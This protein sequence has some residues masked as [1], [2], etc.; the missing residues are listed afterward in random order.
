MEINLQVRSVTFS[1]EIQGEGTGTPTIVL[2]AGYGE[3]SDTWEPVVDRLSELGEVFRYDRAGLGRSGK[4]ENPRTSREM[5]KELYDLLKAAGIEPPYI[6][7]GHSFGGVN[8]RLYASVY[9]ENV[10]GLV[11]VDATPVDYRERFLPVVE[12]TE[13]VQTNFFNGFYL[14]GNGSTRLLACY[15]KPTHNR[16]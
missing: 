7:V 3:D 16:L 1:A 15:E 11:L 14:S 10:C 9:P 12:A 4:S 2:E 13:K 8:A 5:V 6:L